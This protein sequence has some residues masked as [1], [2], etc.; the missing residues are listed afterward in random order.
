MFNPGLGA[1]LCGAAIDQVNNGLMLTLELHCLCGALKL[2]LAVMIIIVS[3]KKSVFFFPTQ[4]LA[5]QLRKLEA[6]DCPYVR[7]RQ[8]SSDYFVAWCSRESWCHRSSRGKRKICN[9]CRAACAMSAGIHMHSNIS[10]SPSNL[11]STRVFA[12]PPTKVTIDGA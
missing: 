6:I 7:N 11:L 8:R 2:F 12:V 10:T 4:F 1:M 9:K 5:S 3:G